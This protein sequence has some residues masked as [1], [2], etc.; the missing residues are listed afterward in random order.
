MSR[1]LCFT[2]AAW[3]LAGAVSAQEAATSASALAP[4]PTLVLIELAGGLDG[5]SAVVPYADAAYA[6]ARPTLAVPAG[7][8]IKLNDTVGLHPAFASLV[9]AWKA[10]DFAIVQGVGYPDPNLSHFRSIAIWES[11]SPCRFNIHP[12]TKKLPKTKS[13]GSCGTSV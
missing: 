4:V 9:D 11:A 2:L 6:K 8:I 13:A 10:G 5:L 3:C 1:I 7:D 12:R